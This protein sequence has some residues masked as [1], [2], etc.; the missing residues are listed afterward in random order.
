MSIGHVGMRASA[1]K[2]RYFISETSWA[3]VGLTQD[4]L[5][6]GTLVSRFERPEDLRHYLDLCRG[7]LVLIEDAHLTQTGTTVRGLRVAVG[8]MPI[9]VVSK[10]ATSAQVVD[11]LSDGADYVLDP[12]RNTAENISC[13]QAIARRGLGVTSPQIRFG[14]LSLDL[15]QRMAQIDGAQL[16]LSPKV[17]E[18]LEHIALRPG[19]VVTREDLLS[20]IYGFS[21]EP[22][23]R[24]FDVYACTLRAAL[25]ATGGVVR[26]ETVRGAGYRLSVEQV[27]AV[28]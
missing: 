25:K 24:V 18:M 26:L 12:A 7:D 2:M 15:D 27:C 16:K 13:L 8:T 19:R 21:N 20:H 22:D 4:I 3:M 28:A 10:T 9:V 1:S 6:N 5:G 17:Y 14:P 11:W 23:I